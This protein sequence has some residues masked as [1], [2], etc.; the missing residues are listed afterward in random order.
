MQLIF[1]VADGFFT[2]SL[3]ACEYNLR[4]G[5]VR[6][7]TGILGTGM[8][9]PNLPKCPVPVSTLYR[10]CRSVRYGYW[11]WTEVTEVPGTCTK[12][13][14]G[15]GGTGINVVPNLQK[16]P[17]PVLMSYRTYRSFRYRC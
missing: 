14:T 3:P 2:S 4:L 13:C 6:Y 12:V 15:T 1:S 16:L 17:V 8:D 7:G 9:V 10:T 11:R 5:F